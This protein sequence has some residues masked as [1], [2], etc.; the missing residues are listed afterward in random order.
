MKALLQRVS[1]ASVTVD[2]APVA[3]IGR[4]LL[5]LLGVERGDTA[6]VAEKL[7]RRSLELRIFPDPAGKMNLSCL[8][9]GGEVLLVSQF[10]L[11]ADTS[12]GRRP[13][14]EPAAP[15]AEAEPLVGSFAAAVR[16]AGARLAE[17]R[18][19]ADMKVGLVNDGPVTILLEADGG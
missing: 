10:T 1:E 5:V 11:C 19:G 7:A 2:G 17:G 16:S 4:G 14:F 6:A 9:I 3:R 13:G 15:P 8:E 12:R 18:F